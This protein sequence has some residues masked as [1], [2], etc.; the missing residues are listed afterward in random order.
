MFGS[1]NW[2]TINGVPV[3]GEELSID[4]GGVY[5]SDGF[6]AF[7]YQWGRTFRH[8]LIGEFSETILELY[9]KKQLVMGDNLSNRL[10]VI[11]TENNNPTLWTTENFIELPIDIRKLE[12]SAD[13]SK[14]F[15]AGSGSL[16]S[17]I[18]LV[19]DIRPSDFQNL[20]D[21]E[22]N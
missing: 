4:E 19:M 13:G 9:G 11:S 15:V 6:G 1:D 21:L 12:A 20:V 2:P 3:V 7:N 8:E 5:D 16:G 18:V 10:A 14:L 17:K 22:S